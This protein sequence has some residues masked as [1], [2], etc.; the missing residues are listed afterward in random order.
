LYAL[1][2]PANSGFFHIE[3]E[4]LA[5]IDHDGYLAIEKLLS[6]EVSFLSLS[7]RVT[8]AKYIVA[9][10][11]RN[12]AF[13]KHLIHEIPSQFYQ[14]ID[15]DTKLIRQI[16]AKGISIP[17]SE[18]ADKLLPGALKNSGASVFQMLL[19][20]NNWVNRI[21][22]MSWHLLDFSDCSGT[23]LLGDRP[24]LTYET[25]DTQLCLLVPLSPKKALLLSESSHFAEKALITPKKKI[26]RYINN[27]MVRKSELDVW[28]TIE[29]PDGKL[30]EKLMRNRIKPWEFAAIENMA[31]MSRVQALA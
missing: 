19:E 18:L 14:D 24:I 27:D 7:E 23:L 29:W 30:I 6:S 1:L 5:D 22:I 12:P 11:I 9:L 16:S 8:I 2:Y 17:P 25:N 13:A 10:R 26:L 15:N 21:T 31:D 4:V 28:S 3:A 20:S